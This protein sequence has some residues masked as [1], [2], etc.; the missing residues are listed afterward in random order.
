MPDT[1][2]G[3]AE[4]HLLPE[5]LAVFGVVVDEDLDRQLVPD[6]GEELGHQHREPAVADE[7]DALPTGDRR[8]CIAIA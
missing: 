7:G 1:E 5:D 4:H 8:D 3:V 6:R 2:L